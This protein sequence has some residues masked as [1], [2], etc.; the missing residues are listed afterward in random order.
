MFDIS[1]RKREDC[2]LSNESA[3]I[4]AILHYLYS[5]QDQGHYQSQDR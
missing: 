2:H 5:R 1:W 3:G 4:M